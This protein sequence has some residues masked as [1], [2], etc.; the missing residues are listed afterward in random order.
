MLLLLWSIRVIL[1]S[2]STA[3]PT[4]EVLLYLLALLEVLQV[5]VTA[6]NTRIYNCNTTR[7]R[8][9]SLL[10]IAVTAIT[11]LG[12]E[13]LP[14]VKPAGGRSCAACISGVGKWILQG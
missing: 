7:L 5:I 4:T 10:I 1:G 11:S 12:H 6:I 14:H 2:P 8:T 3:A 13:Q 9:L